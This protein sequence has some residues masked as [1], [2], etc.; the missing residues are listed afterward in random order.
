MSYHRNIM[1]FDRYLPEARRM[2]ST[3]LPREIRDYTP[4]RH[5]RATSVAP[6]SFSYS[7]P[8]LPVRWRAMSVPLSDC[9]DFTRYVPTDRWHHYYPHPTPTYYYGYDYYVPRYTYYPY[10]YKP[11]LPYQDYHPYNYQ[12]N[13]YQ[14]YQPYNY[15]HNYYQDYQPYNYQHN[16]SDIPS[17]SLRNYYSNNKYSDYLCSSSRDLLGTWKHFSRSN[18]TLKR[19]NDRAASPLVSRELDRYFSTGG[20]TDYVA[21]LGSRGVAEFRHYNYGSV[22]YFGSSDNY[23]NLNKMFQYQNRVEGRSF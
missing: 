16:Y 3:S 15:Q 4:D 11:L 7:E 21:D 10:S 22:P 17:L 13:Y 1:D 6:S 14:D 5:V 19:R 9:L 18:S 20:K 12:P 8:A 23:H 2:R